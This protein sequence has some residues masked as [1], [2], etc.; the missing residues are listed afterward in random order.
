M[1]LRGKI[2]EF[3]AYIGKLSLTNKKIHNDQ[4][5]FIPGVQVSLNIKKSITLID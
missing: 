3:N 1:T 4:V 5:E 2:I